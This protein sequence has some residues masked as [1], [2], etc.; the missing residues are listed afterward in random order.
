MEMDTVIAAVFCSLSV[1]FLY[2]TWWMSLADYPALRPARSARQVSWAIVIYMLFWKA[3]FY[4][5][6]PDLLA[7]IEEGM[8]ASNIM[9]AIFVATAAA[10]AVLLVATGRVRI[11]ALIAGPSFW[12]TSLILVFLASA[13]SS[14]WPEYTL[15]RV[16]ELASFWIIS[17]H[18]FSV[19]DWVRQLSWF[20]LL[21]TLAE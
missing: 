17:H 14:V 2:L 3:L 20:S 21:A 7:L 1:L 8:S 5:E 9:Q 4:Q 6:R 15:F 10:W 13:A 11:G 18:L 16:V 19:K 12:V